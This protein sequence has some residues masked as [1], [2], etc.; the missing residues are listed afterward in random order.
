MVWVFSEQ[1]E[2]DF[3]Q[4]EPGMRRLFKAHMEKLLRMPPRKHL[5]LGRPF[6]CEKVTGQTRLIFRLEG[7]SL[8]A[9]R[10]FSTHKEYEKWFRGMK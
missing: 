6:F 8:R 5:R 1:G 4:L 7:E 10:C 3:G 9:V 2:L